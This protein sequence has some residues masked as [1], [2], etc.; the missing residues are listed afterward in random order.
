MTVYSGARQP[1]LAVPPKRTVVLMV[2]VC[3]RR[4]QNRVSAKRAYEKRAAIQAGV[5]QVR[6]SRMTSHN[7]WQSQLIV[8]SARRTCKY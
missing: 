2:A 4:E 1:L 3:H 8:D 6:C 5:E 7:C